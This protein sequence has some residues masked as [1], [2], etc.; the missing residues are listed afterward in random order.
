M[1]D[2]VGNPRNLL[3]VGGTSD[4]ALAIARRYAQTSRPRVIMAA[5]PGERREAAAADL[6]GV[7]LEVT[8][9]DFNAGDPGSPAKAI[10]EAFALGDVDV[11][12]V[13]Y[14]LLGENERDWTDP[15][16]ARELADVNY[17]SAVE[18]GVLLSNAMKAQ[19]HGTIVA[20][21]SVAGE[22]A[23][24]SNFVYGSSKA[25]FDAFYTGLTYA[26]AEHGIKVLVVRPGFVKSKM[27]AGLKEAP[28]ATTPEAVAEQV[29]DGVRAGKEQIWSPKLFQLVMLVLKLVPRPIF[30][31][32]PF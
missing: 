4:I 12:V 20:L 11:A 27:T 1:I 13:A 9:I 31:K 7:G 25:G 15:G 2:A 17:G 16:S 3:L 26:L 14:G 23:R 10:A 22:R 21:S 5:R 29:V 8:E 18:V 32:L 6:R 28:L 30:R 24:R 19:G